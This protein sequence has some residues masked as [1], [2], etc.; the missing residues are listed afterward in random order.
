MEVYKDIRILGQRGMKICGSTMSVYKTN[1]IIT[2]TSVSSSTPRGVEAYTLFTS[3]FTYP[4][5][6]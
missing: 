6:Y 5:F 1:T 2:L 3:F 4:F